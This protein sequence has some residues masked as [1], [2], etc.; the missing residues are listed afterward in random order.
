LLLRIQVTGIQVEERELYVQSL[1]KSLSSGAGVL[2][3]TSSY[4]SHLVNG[5]RLKT[6]TNP[7]LSFKSFAS[8]TSEAPEAGGRS[9]LEAVLS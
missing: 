8:Y 1:E 6:K 7:V 5:T 2:D 9:A 4:S 3:N